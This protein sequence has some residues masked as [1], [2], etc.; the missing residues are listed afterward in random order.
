MEYFLVAAG[1]LMI[2]TGLI[3]C[4][5][6]VIP[7]VTIA[8]AGLW[9][10]HLTAKAEFHISFLIIIGVLSALSFILDYLLQAANTK[11]TG[12][13]KRAFAGTVIGMIAGVLFFPPFGMIAG[14]FTGALIAELSTG[15][16]LSDSLKVSAGA[17]LVFVAGIVYNV[18]LCGVMLYYS[19]KALLS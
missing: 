10:V 11:F 6:P 14:A 5:V 16:K 1:L 2:V 18:S 17:F 9:L 13:S 3:G 4:I 19:A 12:G 8:Y 15:K 7:S